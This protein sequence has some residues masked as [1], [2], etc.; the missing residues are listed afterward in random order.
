MTKESAARILD[1]ETSWDEL[2]KYDVDT[3]LEA[4]NEACRM[5]ADALREQQD[6]ENPKPLTLDELRQMDGEPVWLMVESGMW[7][8][9]HPKDSVVSLSRG[10]IVG[11]HAIVGKAY[12]HK[13]KEGKS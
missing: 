10:D 12:R 2:R 13:P 6:R 7:G 5:G 8:I 3:L 9:V 4:C 1:P 11:L